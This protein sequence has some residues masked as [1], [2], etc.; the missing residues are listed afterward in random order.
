MPSKWFRN[1]L[2]AR[3][4]S[5]TPPFQSS[6]PGS[7]IVPVGSGDLDLVALDGVH[8]VV[9][10]YEFHPL[11]PDVVSVFLDPVVGASEPGTP[12]AQIFVAASD[13][14][15]TH[16]GAFTN[17]TFSGDGH[18]P[19]TIDEIRWGDSFTDVT[20]VPEPTASLLVGAAVATLFGLRRRA[21]SR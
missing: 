9:M 5:P 2:T 3:N 20:P 10:K 7:S 19:G 1:R 11:D 8:L 13:L 21:E 14:F 17:F 4:A 12:E 6:W 16:H 15:I 18:I